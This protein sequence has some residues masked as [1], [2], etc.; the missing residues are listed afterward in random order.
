[1][2]ERKT[3]QEEAENLIL[4]AVLE[5]KHGALCMLGRHCSIETPPY[6]INRE[7][8]HMRLWRPE[9]ILNLIIVFKSPFY[10]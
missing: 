8:R 2:K 5:L 3:H 4:F 6:P 1:M 7:L 9:V 10:I